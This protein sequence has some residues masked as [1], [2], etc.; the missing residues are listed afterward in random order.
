MTDEDGGGK[1]TD[2]EQEAADN[3]EAEMAYRTAV[4]CNPEHR[5]ARNPEPETARAI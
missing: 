3:D 4:G 2:E 5:T 1:V